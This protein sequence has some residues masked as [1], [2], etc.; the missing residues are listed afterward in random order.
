MRKIPI[1]IFRF[2]IRISAFLSS[3]IYGIVRQPLLILTLILGPF[4]I[5]LAFGLG[6]HNEPLK[7]R[8]LFVIPS[9]DGEVAQRIEEYAASLGPQL[10]YMGVTDDQARASQQLLRGEIDIM[11]LVPDNAYESIRNNKPVTI[12][13]LHNEIDPIK[14]DYIEIFG[15][16]YINEM[17]RRVLLTAI[18]GSQQE[19]GDR[20][21]ALNTLRET[22]AKLRQA[23]AA[24]N[25][26]A[27]AEHQQ[28]LKQDTDR[29]VLAVG[30]TL[31]L[32]GGIQQAIGG[33]DDGNRE[34]IQNL[35]NNVDQQATSASNTGG[36][37]REEMAATEGKLDQLE[38]D[39]TELE[40]LLT[41]FQNAE[42]AVLIQPFENTMESISS[43]KIEDADFFAPAVIALLLQHLSVT[44]GA[45]SIVQERNIGT[46]ELFRV[47]PIS[48]LETLLGKYFS[49]ML[50]SAVLALLL[51]P[52]VIYGLQVPMLGSWL[53]YSLILA[54]LIFTSIG[55]GF[56]ISL[57]AHSTTGAMQYAM[58]VLL[59]SMFFSG[60]FIGLYFMRAPIH[61]I[62]RAVPATYGIE[63]LQDV[64]LRGRLVNELQL[65]TLTVL[66]IGFFILAWLL[67]R[68]AMS[69][70]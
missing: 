42:A 40:T 28:E 53:N 13:L 61:V 39:L 59:A 27:V 47:S 4:F 52:I 29:L 64:M 38:S 7:L 24:Q 9:P 67:L 46:M 18:R 17:N 36:T 14:L 66:G 49:Y 51:T 43:I 32:V 12:E 23:T 30:T 34:S 35:L 31:G 8:T 58:I 2:I 55:L 54:A 11:A 44:F 15:Q 48:P 33:E 26:T 41:E 3:E 63:L 50:L 6:Y 37:D 70:T 69:Q 60:A 5:L 65:G 25:Q 68:R 10:V 16:F 21:E 62:S 45:L 56:V 57:L 20:E 19:M 1:E 22:S